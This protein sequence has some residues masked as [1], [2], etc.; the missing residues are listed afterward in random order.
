MTVCVSVIIP[1]YNRSCTIKRA[2]ESVLSENNKLFIGEI[3][4]VD[5]GSSEDESKKLNDYM[6]GLGS[7][8][9]NEGIDFIVKKYPVNKNAAFARN[10]GIKIS[11]FDIVAF[12]DSDDEWLDGKLRKQIS[13]LE[14]NAIVFTQYSKINSKKTKNIGIYPTLFEEDNIGDYLLKGLG[15]IQT[16]TMLM[17]RSVAEKILFNPS[18]KKYQDWDFSIR[19]W[20]SEVNFLFLN[21]P[22]VKYFLDAD[23]RIGNVVS[24]KLVGDFL[25]SV[26]G[27]IK[28][29][30]VSFFLMSS[31]L[32]IDI[33]E[34]KYFDTLVKLLKIS[35][36]KILSFKRTTSIFLHLIKVLLI[37]LSK[38][39]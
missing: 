38:R 35:T 12:L 36:F 5:D 33:S 1:F 39:P 10:V 15:H 24:L 31:S 34:E 21:E 7:I 23:D 25:V 19:A 22:L 27:M 28:E 37:R 9:G 8:Y 16:S 13:M 29:D 18:L 17:N 14:E 30:T 20:N 26:D 6:S 4:V 11:S 32:W 3:I 2:V